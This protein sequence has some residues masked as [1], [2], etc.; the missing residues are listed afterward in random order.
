T[1]SVIGPSVAS[2][3][4]FYG[5]SNE[6]EPVIPVV[7]LAGLAALTTWRRW[8]A[9]PRAV[10]YGVLGAVVAVVVGW[11]RL[12]ADVGG[13]VT[14]AAGFAGG[15]AFGT[16]RL[17]RRRIA[18]LVAVPVVAVVALV[19]LDL[20][21]RG[22]DHLSNNLSRSGGRTDM[23]ELVAR[24]Y[25]LAFHV[26]GNGAIDIRLA[27]ALVGVAVV[28]RNQGVVLGGP[29]SPAWRAALLGGLAAGVG[30][31]LANDSGPVLLINAVF[32]LA[33]IVLYLGGRN[34]ASQA[35][36]PEESQRWD[37]VGSR[38]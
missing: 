2:G 4:R 16:G 28:V 24:R 12:G 29:V 18:V 8:E 32:A 21:S 15:V 25:Q 14:V 20:V 27:V 13:V 34:R 30:G 38:G 19:G 26:L 7:A 22:G 33:G 9:V 11:G 3:S 5:I 23:W 6:L 31:A 37:T 10:V 17:T 35:W 36:S 1:E